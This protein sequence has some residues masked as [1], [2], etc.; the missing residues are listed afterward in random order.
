LYKILIEIGVK[1]NKLEE[2]VNDLQKMTVKQNKKINVIELLNN[3]NC[4]PSIEFTNIIPQ[5]DISEKD[6]EFLLDNE[7]N[8]TLN[9]IFLRNLYHFDKSSN[10]IISF[11]HQPNI[12]YVYT[13]S[14]WI[15][16]SDDKLILFLKKILSIIIKLFLTWKTTNE[17][18]LNE[19]DV[20][21]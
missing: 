21:S 6:I 12:L 9:S 15:K 19:N 14:N 16:L 11:V 20:L 10:P 7:F 3:H 1:Y 13:D 2:K 5:I 8:D 18:E 4:H 17:K